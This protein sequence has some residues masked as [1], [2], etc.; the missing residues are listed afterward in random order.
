MC[1]FGVEIFERIA[2]ADPESIICPDIPDHYI[3]I[4]NYWV[5]YSIVLSLYKYIVRF[6]S[7]ITKAKTSFSV[8]LICL[9]KIRKYLKIKSYPASL[10]RFIGAVAYVTSLE[11]SIVERS[12]RNVAGLNL[13]TRSLKR[14]NGILRRRQDFMWSQLTFPWKKMWIRRSLFQ[15]QP[16]TKIE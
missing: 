3:V 5:I 13:E 16:Y 2:T 4:K 6:F 7:K 15:F 14:S 8:S 9:S 12:V 11:K 1:A 10:E